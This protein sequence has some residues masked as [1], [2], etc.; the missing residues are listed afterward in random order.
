MS[1]R[2]N[3]PKK[4]ARNQRWK[5]ALIPIL[6]MVL[7]G[8]L[9]NNF[10]STEPETEL[11]TPT[12]PGSVVDLVRPSADKQDLSPSG[13]TWPEIELPE[14]GVI[15]P[16]ASLE[17]PHAESNSSTPDQDSKPKLIT[18]I[19]HEQHVMQLSQEPLQ[20]YFQAGDR[21]VMMVGNQVFT[22]GQPVSDHF[23][24]ERL[25]M[26]KIVF[27]RANGEEPTSDK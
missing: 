25:E 27:G 18:A 3:R 11:A 10:R 2:R 15:N 7:L 24:V 5:I 13:L 17:K 23:V 9:Y 22:Q 1:P 12:K 26:D 19:N 8:V 21:R 20:Y 4:A 6:L 16:F 14:V